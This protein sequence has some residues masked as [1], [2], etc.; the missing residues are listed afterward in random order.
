MAVESKG[1]ETSREVIHGDAFGHHSR[2]G[3][4]PYHAKENPSQ[5][6]AQRDQREGRVGAGDEHVDGR[7]I[8]NVKD[9]AGAGAH[10]RVIE[11]GAEIDQHQR[12]GKDGATDNEPR[13]AARGSNDQI[14]GSRNGERGADAVRD[15]VGQ[16]V[17]QF[18]VG[19]HK[20]MIVRRSRRGNRLA[21][22]TLR[23]E[24]ERAH[25]MGISVPACRR[26]ARIALEVRCMRN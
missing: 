3:Q 17:A 21:R 16:N 8:E 9:V 11:R 15:G 7:V 1:E 13:R 24:S 5:R 4:R 22:R 18:V 19:V 25:V 2:H 20:T 14:D 26:A 12:A 10:Q 6:A 23:S